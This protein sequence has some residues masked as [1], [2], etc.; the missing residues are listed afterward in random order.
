[1][2][3]RYYRDLYCR[4]FGEEASKKAIKHVNKVANKIER[5]TRQYRICDDNLKILRDVALLHLL[6]DEYVGS[7]H[8]SSLRMH[9]K[10]LISLRENDE[11]PLEEKNIDLYKMIFDI[12]PIVAFVRMFDLSVIDLT[13]LHETKIGSHM[14]YSDMDKALCNIA[15]TALRFYR[16]LADK[17]GYHDVYKDINLFAVHI[18]YP[19]E[20][21]KL[22]KK[23]KNG[24]L[25][26]EL[27]K[28]YE[29]Y[30][31]RLMRLIENSEKKG[32]RVKKFYGRKTK[33]LG[34]WVLK[35]R[36]NCLS[37][38]DYL[39][40]SDVIAYT[41][42]TSELDECYKILDLLSKTFG[43][44]SIHIEDKNKINPPDRYRSIHVD[45]CTPNGF[46]PNTVE[47]HIR[48]AE[49]QRKY[50]EGEW[51]H[52][53]LKSPGLRLLRDTSMK[54]RDFTLD[55]VGGKQPFEKV[56][57]KMDDRKESKYV[58]VVWEGKEMSVPLFDGAT[59]VDIVASVLPEETKN[60]VC[61]KKLSEIAKENDTII[62]EKKCSSITNRT[63]NFL[64]ERVK[65][66]KARRLLLNLKK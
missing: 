7:I 54:F 41:I 32:I 20:I 24:R 17:L 34:G 55:F 26:A 37:I 14:Y 62:L 35:L 4:A 49:Q 43:P 15:E 25:R 16:G 3:T 31:K 39:E 57:G 61:N 64:L 58:R 2:T 13:L 56:V 8:D 45:V 33:D 28:T 36:R 9:F 51:A 60:F 27:T 46:T 12:D 30:E 18:L 10:A 48:S 38:D 66:E 52:E 59:I 63:I 44:E 19:E 21:A 1:M 6:P 40:I 65:T 42:V 5:T 47:I 22:K 23:L 11:L 29:Y 53:F 50:F